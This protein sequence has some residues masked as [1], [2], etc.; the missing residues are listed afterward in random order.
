MLLSL[1][2][3][4]IW[5]DAWNHRTDYFQVI[6]ASIF[7]IEMT[8]IMDGGWTFF[9]FSFYWSDV[10][11]LELELPERKLELTLLSVSILSHLG[12]L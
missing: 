11:E 2:K 10:M 3:N 9:F 12:S 4:V 6:E 7:L 1:L 8:C 5:L